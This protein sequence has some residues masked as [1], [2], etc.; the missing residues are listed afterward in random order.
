MKIFVKQIKDLGQVV[1]GKT[2]PTA[3]Q[4]YWGS[5]FK[6]VTPSDISYDTY[7]I[8][9]T[10]RSVTDEAYQRFKNQFIPKNSVVYTCIASLGKIGISS[11]ECLTNQQINSLIPN[12][13]ND[14]RYLYYLLKANSKKINQTASGVASPIINKTTFENINLNVHNK[15]DQIRIGEILFLYDESIQNNIRRIELLEKSAQLLYKEWFVRFRFPGFEHT[16]FVDGIPEGWGKYKIKSL[17][18]VITGKTPPTSDPDNYG[19]DFMFVKTPDMHNNVFVIESS[20]NLSEKGAKTQTNKFLPPLSLMISCIGTIGVVAVTT[21]ICQT[22]QQINSIVLYN[23][24]MIWYLFYTLKSLK[25]RMEAMGGGATM[26]NINKTK[27]E[28]LDIVLPTQRLIEN[29]YEMV[30]HN[31]SQILN[32][33]KQNKLLRYS[34]ELLLPKLIIG[35]LTI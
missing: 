5:G 12:E 19:S 13:D 8:N 31:F 9:N 28:N 22:N 16:K 18:D 15:D 1:T 23:K 29:Y 14:P 2:P 27:F 11:S 17:G 20:E 35:D 10:E 3:N 25:Q 26:N 6:F 34:R 7:Y 32:L 30:N 21:E 33:Q 4:N 24:T